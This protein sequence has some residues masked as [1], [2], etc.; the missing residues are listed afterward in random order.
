MNESRVPLAKPSQ[1]E[2][3]YVQEQ[4]S[5]LAKT[6][7]EALDEETKL[8]FVSTP[9]DLVIQSI[10]QRHNIKIELSPEV[11]KRQPVVHNGKGK[12]KTELAKMLGKM[13]LTYVVKDD[14]ILIQ[15]AKRSP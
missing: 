2:R 6:P 11:K 13:K 7:Q 5:L 8:F 1:S 10:A 9:L 3:T 14:Y 15:P 12:L 4:E